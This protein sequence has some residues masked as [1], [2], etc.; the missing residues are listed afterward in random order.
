MEQ[1]RSIVLLLTIMGHGKLIINQR[2]NGHIYS[3]ML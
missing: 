1:V 3:L 2:E